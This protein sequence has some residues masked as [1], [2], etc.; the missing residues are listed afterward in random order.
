MNDLKGLI[1]AITKAL[2]DGKSVRIS[3]TVSATTPNERPKGK[4]RHHVTCDA[5]GWENWY[6]TTFTAERGLGTHHRHCALWQNTVNHS[7][8]RKGR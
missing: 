5:C 3:V 6:T 8:H 2:E 4:G 1:E 7:E